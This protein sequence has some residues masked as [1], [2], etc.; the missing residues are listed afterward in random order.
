[1]RDS[2]PS[3]TT[4]RFGAV[5]AVACACILCLGLGAEAAQAEP[6]PAGVP[7][8][9]KLKFDEE[10]NSTGVETSVWTKGWQN[11][12]ISGPM[13][14]QCINSLLTSQPGDG[15]L[16]LAVNLE[17]HECGGYSNEYTG[18]L[19]ESNPAD[20]VAGHGGFTYSYGYVEWRAYVAGPEGGALP[21][22]PGLW[23]LPENHETEI[24]TMEG[25]G[26]EANFHFHHFFSPEE[27]VGN[28]VPGGYAGRWHT[29]G[30]D[31]EPNV[32][33]FYYDGN[34]VGQINSA[35]INSTPQYLV[36]DMVPPEV[37]RGSG[38]VDEMKVDYV[39]V[40]QHPG[41]PT[42]TTGGVSGVGGESATLSGTVNPN[43]IETGY[44]FEYGETTAYGMHSQPEGKMGAGWGENPVSATISGLVPGR[45]YHYRLA[46]S[47]SYGGS[48]GA[49]H[50]F[51]VPSAQHNLLSNGSFAFGAQAAPSCGIPSYWTAYPNGG[52]ENYC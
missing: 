45:T 17:H 44:A 32:V 11:E 42:A 52:S 38:S 35:Y 3:R 5:L 1:M 51:T 16:H 26:G 25:L 50:T 12:G 4:P 20:G 36:M 30:V 9:W 8:T 46:A 23:S 33:T 6:M 22:W 10:F 31:W 14:K 39:R 18:A 15:Y 21:D 43:G 37:K 2:R 7:G 28:P 27:H 47:N 29:Y 41:P 13:S 24:D 48:D 49:D 19:V 40:W 34:V